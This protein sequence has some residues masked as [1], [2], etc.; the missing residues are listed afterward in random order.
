MYRYYQYNNSTSKG[1]CLCYQG[2][3]SDNVNALCKP[4]H[5]SCLNCTTSST[6][7]LACP[8]SR[9]FDTN[10]QYCVCVSQYYQNSQSLNCLLCLY[11]CAN[12]TDYS[13]CTDCNAA[14]FRTLNS[15]TKQCTCNNGY[16]DDGNS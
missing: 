15:I 7:C 3:Y 1:D 11:S 8:A 14:K 16:Y 6:S 13:I 2:Y 12:C 10:N 9:Q 5:Y 4:C